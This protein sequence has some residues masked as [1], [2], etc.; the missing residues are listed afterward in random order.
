MCTSLRYEIRVRGLLGPTA[1]EAFPTLESGRRGNDTVLTGPVADQ[2]ALFG[3]LHS[4][5][6]LGL[7]LL[8]LHVCGERIASPTKPK[9]WKEHS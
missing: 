9:R 4:I 5:E 8:D 1:L 7:D 3:V 6:S 2:A